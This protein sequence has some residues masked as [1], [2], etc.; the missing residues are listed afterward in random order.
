MSCKRPQTLDNNSQTEGAVTAGRAHS[1]WILP[2]IMI[3]I[4]AGIWWMRRKSPEYPAAYIGD[5]A[6][7]LW[8][9][10]AQVRQ[11]V[12]TLHYGDK[13]AIL[14]R[15][16]EQVQ[17]RSERGAEGWIEARL[18]MQPELWQQTAELVQLVRAMPVQAVG[19]TR[20]R[21]NVRIGPGRDAP[22]VFQFGPNESL[23]VFNRKLAKVSRPAATVP[24]DKDSAAPDTPA[25]KD[26]D[27]DWLLVL[28]RQPTPVAAGA[29]A[30]AGVS[31]ASAA[32]SDDTGPIAGWVLAQFVTLDPPQ[33]IGDYTSA[34][35]MRP[36]A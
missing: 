34:A 12:T 10:T 19:H 17:V 26:R 8:S 30:G 4:T 24:D 32:T 7:I 15:S 23:A 20:A 11:P 3:A 28:R 31:A 35:G 6:A 14:R 13:V 9:T 5:R 22:A 29:S 36:I 1:R 2:L 27:E 16:G 25:V 21:S 18:L 33:P